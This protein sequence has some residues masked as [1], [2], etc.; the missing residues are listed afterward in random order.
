M[1]GYNGIDLSSGTSKG[2]QSEHGK[3]DYGLR[4]MQLDVGICFD[5]GDASERGVY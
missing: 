4:E 3:M 1:L 5:A 2:S